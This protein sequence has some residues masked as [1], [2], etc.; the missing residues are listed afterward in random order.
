MVYGYQ[1]AVDGV[2]MVYGWQ[3]TVDGKEEDF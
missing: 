1:L 2:R 3:L